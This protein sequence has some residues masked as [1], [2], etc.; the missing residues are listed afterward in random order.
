MEE[1]VNLERS[2]AL[3]TQAIVDGYLY[4]TKKVT[5]KE[6]LNEKGLE[7]VPGK[8]YNYHIMILQEMFKEEL[9]I[10]GLEL[11]KEVEKAGQEF[12]SGELSDLESQMLTNKINLV[13]GIVSLIKK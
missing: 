4:S 7:N 2:A 11:E 9:A 1:N 13:S 8:L 3:V 12:K 6:F 10:L 5:M